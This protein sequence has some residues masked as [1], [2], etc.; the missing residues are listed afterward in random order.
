[1]PKEK[2]ANAVEKLGSPLPLIKGTTN[3]EN[4]DY[5]M[6]Q[7][8]ETGPPHKQLQHTL[9]LNRLNALVTLWSKKA[10]K[11]PRKIKGFD[12]ADEKSGNNLP[13]QLPR[14]SLAAPAQEETLHELAKGPVHELLYTSILL[15][16]IES[17]IQTLESE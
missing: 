13:V 4:V 15:Q 3:K 6:Q 10:G 14:Q 11:K 2:T 5:V 1:M 8:C 7:I 16:A 17:M 12:L 9:V